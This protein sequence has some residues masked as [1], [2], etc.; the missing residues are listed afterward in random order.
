MEGLLDASDTALIGE[1]RSA[2]CGNS[3]QLQR[4]EDALMS[5]SFK[6]LKLRETLQFF[7][8]EAKQLQSVLDHLMSD[9][10][11]LETRMSSLETEVSQLQA[12]V[13]ERRELSENIKEECEMIQGELER[14]TQ[15]LFEEVNE[16][17]SAEARSKH[18]RMVSVQ[19]M[20]EEMDRIRT[21]IRA[22]HKRFQMLKTKLV[23]SGTKLL[24]QTSA[25]NLVETKLSDL[26]AAA[27]S[28][29]EFSRSGSN[30]ALEAIM[31]GLDKDESSRE[32][33]ESPVAQPNDENDSKHVDNDAANN[34]NKPKS[35]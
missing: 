16:M 1:L 21:K 25:P 34:N 26:K 20:K 14:L 32:S 17:V 15:V 28:S 31:K 10:Q 23:N 27:R 22:R 19:E 35:E 11:R 7:D 4:V 24:K 9:R 3:E 18:E 2:L 13:T 12:A 8:D 6:Q 33:R 29:G 30:R 5:N